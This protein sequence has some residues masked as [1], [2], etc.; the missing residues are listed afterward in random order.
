MITG[1]LDISLSSSLVPNFGYL[2]SVTSEQGQ[3][4]KVDFSAVLLLWHLFK[5]ICAQFRIP[6]VLL[7][8]WIKHF[9]LLSRKLQLHLWKLLKCMEIS[10][11]SISTFFMEIAVS[12]LKI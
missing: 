9:N 7:L 8:G 6:T 2:L 3:E 12:K 4:V 11:N 1:Q 10:Y 5:L